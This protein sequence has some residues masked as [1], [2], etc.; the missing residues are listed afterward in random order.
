MSQ[1]Q[2]CASSGMGNNDIIFSKQKLS[3]LVH[4]TRDSFNPGLPYFSIFRDMFQYSCD[5]SPP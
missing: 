2:I 3:P 1:S 4:S 5:T